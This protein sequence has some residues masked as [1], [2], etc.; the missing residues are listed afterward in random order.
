MK[1]S[2][3]LQLFKSLNSLGNLT[4]VKFAYA[5]SKNLGLLKPEIVAL[6][7]SLEPSPEFT[8][9]DELRVELAKKHAKKDDKGN[10][11]IENARYVLENEEEFNKEWEALKVEHKP[12]L[13]GRQAQLDEYDKLL[14]TEC[15]INLH[16]VKLEFVPE[17]INVQQIHAISA[18]IEE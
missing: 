18:I 9:Y 4:G 14:E 5:V 11:I 6:D 7:K 17:A 1:K 10:P 12:A 16:K 3:A 13:D 8:K 2:E 15:D